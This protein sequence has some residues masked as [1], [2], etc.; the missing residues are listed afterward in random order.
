MEEA[1]QP[2]VTN[3]EA[4]VAEPIQLIC[5]NP[6]ETLLDLTTS[7]G[8]KMWWK[9]TAGSKEKFELNSDPTNAEDFKTAIDKASKEFCWSNAIEDLP[10]AWDAD[11]NI[12]RTVDIMSDYRDITLKE[13]ITASG[14]RFDCTFEADE[15]TH[16]FMI[17]PTNDAQENLARL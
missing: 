13:M 3:E 16:D 7:Q 2:P 17:Q 14:M 4:T 15:I 1:Q 5:T 12:A 9:A 8:Q 6:Y 11:G 10:I